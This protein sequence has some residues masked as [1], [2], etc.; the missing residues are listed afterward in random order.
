VTVAA[1]SQKQVALLAQP[2]VG[3]ELL[4]RARVWRDN[5]REPQLVLRMMNKTEW[6]LGLPL[7][8]GTFALFDRY[9]G[10]PVLLGEGTTADRAVGEKAEVELGPASN[11]K[12]DTDSQDKGRDRSLVTLTVTND[13]SRPILFEAM[14]A[15][16]NER[17]GGFSSKIYAEGRDRIWRVGVPAN[18][19][20]TLSYVLTD[21]D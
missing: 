20:R 2:G 1:K 9:R 10:R 16:G 15:S 14:I 6:G 7:P 21:R 12:V 3:V 19:S 5:A 8:A 17:I 11:V 18:S 13:E 4:Y